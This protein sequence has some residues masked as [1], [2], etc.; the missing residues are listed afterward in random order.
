MSQNTITFIFQNTDQ[1]FDNFPFV[2]QVSV[3]EGEVG[4]VVTGVVVEDVVV[5][6]EE[7][8]EEEEEVRHFGNILKNIKLQNHHPTFEIKRGIV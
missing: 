3:Q 1:Y 6:E 8:G 2:F 4:L 7:A 5:V